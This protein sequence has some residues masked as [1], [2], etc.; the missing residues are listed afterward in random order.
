MIGGAIKQLIGLFVDDE[1]LAAAILCVVAIVS[2]LAL[3]GAAPSWVAALLLTLAMPAVLVA[4]VLRSV[5]RE[6]RSR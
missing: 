4:S 5:R 6:R 1:L 3:S 2:T